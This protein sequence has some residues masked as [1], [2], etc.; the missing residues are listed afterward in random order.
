MG[1]GGGGGGGDDGGGEM[2]YLIE[3][4]TG[5]DKMVKC[6]MKVEIGCSCDGEGG[7]GDDMHGGGG[8]LM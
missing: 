8:E 2:E 3:G 4:R 7:G 6:M 1:G 5:G